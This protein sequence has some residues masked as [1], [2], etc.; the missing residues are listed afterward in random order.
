MGSASGRREGGPSPTRQGGDV[1]FC[2]LFFRALAAAHFRKLR[3]AGGLRIAERCP[4]R[5]SQD[6][7]PFLRNGGSVRAA[8]A[9]VRAGRRGA[10]KRVA[11]RASPEAA[12]PVRPLPLPAAAHTVHDSATRR[13]ATHANYPHLTRQTKQVYKNSEKSGAGPWTCCHLACRYRVR[14]PLAG[15]P[16][17]PKP[18]RERSLLEEPP[19]GGRPG[20]EGVLGRHDLPP[21]RLRLR[22][23]RQVGGGEDLGLD[24][25]HPPRQKCQTVSGIL[26][27]PASFQ[28][29]SGKSPSRGRRPASGKVRF[30][31]AAF[32][33]VSSEEMLDTVERI[34][35]P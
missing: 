10:A 4:P 32:G 13:R 24:A 23:P 11:E 19:L 12:T 3:G 35:G 18:W 25:A 7:T 17:T 27:P 29:V 16:G 30:G 1:R 2:P 21:Q 20:P 9:L 22:Q 26:P 14:G 28:T 34:T 8:K 33:V 5:L 15:C 6:T 31:E